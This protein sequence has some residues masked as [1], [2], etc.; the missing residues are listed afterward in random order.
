MTTVRD[1][2]TGLQGQDPEKPLIFETADGKI[3]AGYHVTE[4]IHSV[5]TGVDCGGNL[6]IWEDARLQ[7]L[8]GEGSA[9]MQ[10]GKFT[11][12]VEKSLKAIPALASSPINVEF[13]HGNAAL[14]LMSLG[15]LSAQDDAVFLPLVGTA[16]VC[17]PAQRTTLPLDQAAGCCGSSKPPAKSGRRVL[18]AVF[19]RGECCA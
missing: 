15:E 5:S 14:S 1:L 12:I 8:D 17:K 19:K 11:A 6:E 2:L 13:G 9:H 4:L 7:L 16:A 10:V 3:G 18:D